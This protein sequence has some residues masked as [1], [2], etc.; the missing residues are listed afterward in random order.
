MRCKRSFIFI[1]FI[2]ISSFA[3]VNAQEV[4]VKRSA[5]I[6]QYKGKPYYVHFVK[7]GETLSALSKAYNVTAK[8][9]IADNPSVEQGLKLDMVVLI[10]KREGSQRQV[11]A[12]EE[13]N[14]KGK[15][16]SAIITDGAMKTYVV[17]PK[18]SLY[19]IARK[20]KVSQED[21]LKANPGFK[22]LKIGMNL[23]IPTPSASVKPQ[24]VKKVETTE[25]STEKKAVKK[26]LTMK[27]IEVKQGETLYAI[28]KNNNIS[29]EKLLEINPTIKETDV[30][31]IGTRMRVPVVLD[32]EENDKTVSP[33]ETQKPKLEEAKKNT[34][35]KSE[36]V[37]PAPV[38]TNISCY[39]E[40]NLTKTYQVALILPLLL[41]QMQEVT[42]GNAANMSEYKSLEFI[43]FYAGFVTAADMLAQYGLKTKIHVVDGDRLRDSTF[44]VNALNKQ[45]MTKMDLLVGPLFANS[46]PYAA[47]FAQ[48]NTIPIVNPL[49]KRDNIIKDN[50]YV[51]KVQP[52]DEGTA[53]KM[54][55]FILKDYANANIILLRRDA[56]EL[57]G[58]A[59]ATV[60]MLRASLKEGSFKGII[61]E[62]TFTGEGIQA[63]NK[64]LAD[65]GKN[66]LVFFTNNRASILTLLS[67]A[68]ID[69]KGT[70]DLT[71]MGMDNWDKYELPAGILKRFNYHQLS[72]SYIDYDDELTKAFVQ[73]FR[74]K[75]GAM[76]EESK[77]AFLGFD[78]GWNFLKSM[79]ANGNNFQKCMQNQLEKGIQYDFLFK[80]TNVADGLENT[81]VRI[82]KLENNKLIKLD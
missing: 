38:S 35:E 76:P 3:N 45:G 50:P 81:N 46:F 6:D 32:I 24:P 48:K 27:W 23:N 56:K 61:K 17:Q 21:I 34:V 26:A 33:K 39:N 28:A 71:L 72:T 31:S 52:S 78:I 44:I 75:Y 43:Q 1:F 29:V 9:I 36:T 67:Q 8:E 77:Y 57:K 30:L 63:V 41:N 13:E 80:N 40:G 19:G 5:I 14:I 18:E 11:A 58:V 42:D 47:E 25:Q 10:P 2:F 69:L 54:V 62:A 22:G 20:F 37:L 16:P 51:I 65:Q 82:I 64:N 66:L 74:S 68:N 7:E 4:N 55:D 53:K 49:S 12:D 59:D 15:A 73:N 70:P 60:K 79:M